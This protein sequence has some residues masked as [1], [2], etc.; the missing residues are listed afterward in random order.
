MRMNELE[1]KLLGLLKGEHSSLSLSFNDQVGPNYCTVA[2]GIELGMFD[3]SRW[4]SEEE[5][6]RAVETNRAWTL[7]WYPDTPNGFCAV[8]ASSLEA[9]VAAVL[10][11][12]ETDE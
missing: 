1:T 9:V 11:S 2:E 8:S 5:K 12:V 7:H 6:Q 4:A 10:E 3:S